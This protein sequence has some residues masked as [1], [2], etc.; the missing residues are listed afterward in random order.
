ML[1]RVMTFNIRNC[2][3]DDGTNS[4]EFRKRLLA[5]AIEDE[6]PDVMGLQEVFYRQREFLARALPQ[7]E[8]FGE[9]RGGGRESEA[10]L[11]C[12]LHERFSLLE[13][14]NVWLSDTPEVAGSKTWGN[15]NVRMATWARL[16]RRDDGARFFVVNC[17][18]DHQAEL[19]RR[20]GAAQLC[21]LVR[22][23]AGEDP[24]ILMGDFNAWPHTPAY[25]LLTGELD[26]DGTRGELHDAWEIAAERPEDTRT[27]H[28]WGE[29]GEVG[30]QARIDWIMVRP[31]LEV[32]RVT[33]PTYREGD[34]LPSDHYPVV[35]EV[36]L[37]AD[38][39]Q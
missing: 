31:R 22:D 14:G 35:A 10:A 26:W 24:A 13:G 3:A 21:D 29:M 16:R 12:Y 39:E 9:H 5:R 4:W 8:Q 2:I 19:A 25:Q 28:G 36:S 18:L 23:R 20:K 37:R 38:G 27:F 30:E 1:V 34:R 7:Y 32:V 11:L 17:H 6:A 15:R 33:R